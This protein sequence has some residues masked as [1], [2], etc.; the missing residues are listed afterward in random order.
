MDGKHAIESC[1]LC[2]KSKCPSTISIVTEGHFLGCSQ[3]NFKH[4]QT[5]QNCK[6]FGSQPDSSVANRYD[7]C[8]SGVDEVMQQR[9]RHC[10]T[11]SLVNLINLSPVVLS[12]L[13][14]ST[15]Q[16][17][18]RPPSPEDI[19]VA[20]NYWQIAEK[21]PDHVMIEGN[22]D[23]G[24]ASLTATELRTLKPGICLAPGVISAFSKVFVD[25]TNKIRPPNSKSSFFF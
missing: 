25:F 15:L 14:Q 21:S 18:I 7:N 19:S 4:F 16:E 1:V 6:C 11:L 8:F 24:I 22:A 3:S 9:T 2:A 17:L 20:T 5:L 23:K 12:S 13:Q 10:A